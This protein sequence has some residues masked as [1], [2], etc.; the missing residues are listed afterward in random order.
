MQLADLL[1]E[2]DESGHS[3][4]AAEIVSTAVDH[5]FV[6]FTDA[7]I[8]A[9]PFAKKYGLVVVNHILRLDG[10]KQCQLKIYGNDDFSW[11]K[12]FDT[13]SEARMVL[14]EIALF[15]PCSLKEVIHHYGLKFTN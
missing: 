1:D 10:T 7:R 12:P 5:D 6:E 2:L 4:Y 14:T 9:G 11:A 13:Q 15:Q 8:L 3:A